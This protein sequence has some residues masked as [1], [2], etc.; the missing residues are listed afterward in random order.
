MKIALALLA[1]TLFAGIV[2]AADWYNAI[3]QTQPY[4]G[5]RPNSYQ[6]GV[7]V[8][9]STTFVFDNEWNF[10]LQ[11]GKNVTIVLTFQSGVGANAAFS[12]NGDQGSLVTPY[13]FS[14]QLNS[15]NPR[16][17]WSGILQTSG[18]YRIELGNVGRET[19]PATLQV[20]IQAL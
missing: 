8:N 5:P 9:Q 2:V 14:S 6:E 18:S 19:Q 7:L 11:A 15:T 1:V 10:L 16:Q 13:L 12:M 17:E 20:F 3:H 4:V